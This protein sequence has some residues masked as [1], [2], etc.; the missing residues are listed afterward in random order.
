MNDSSINKS[1]IDFITSLPMVLNRT[2]DAIMPP[3]RDLFPEF[4]V[5]EQQWQV[6]RLLWEQKH[7]T[8][9]QISNFTL[10]PAPSLVGILDR[11]EKKGLVSRLRSTLDRRQVHIAIT[12]KGQKLQEKVIPRVQSIQELNKK[13]FSTEDWV[14]INSILNKFLSTL[15]E[16][17]D[18][19]K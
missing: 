13:N 19:A 7:L 10:L 3:Y 1:A 12:L 4:G 16:S 2:L 18:D 6:L 17:Q 15:T 5:T 9:S 11:L 8:S 14:Q